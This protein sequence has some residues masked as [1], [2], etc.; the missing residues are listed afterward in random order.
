V[1]IAEVDLPL[2]SLMNGDFAPA[3]TNSLKILGMFGFRGDPLW[4]NN[5]AHLPVFDLLVALFFYIGLGIS[6]WRWRKERYL[7]IVLWLF[8]AAIPSIVTIDAPSSIRIINALPI[9]TIIPVIGLEVIQFFRPLST[10]LERLSPKTVEILALLL[11]IALLGVNIT[12]TASAI[13]YVWP[14][15]A[16]VQ[17][18]WQQAFTEIADYLDSS[19]GERAIALGGWT[20]ESMDP[21]TMDLLLR[22]EDLNLRYF[23]PTQSLLLPSPPSGEASTIFLP[24]VLPLEPILADRLAGWGA[25]QETLGTFRL[26]QIPD[27][28]AIQPQFQNETLFGNE[29]T[30]L[31]YDLGG[32]TEKLILE[33]DGGRI[34]LLTYW[35]VVAPGSGPRR[36]FLHAVTA[37]GQIVAQ[38]DRNGAPAAYWQM[39]DILLQRHTLQVPPN[40]NSLIYALGLYDPETGQRLSTSNGADHLQL[41]I[42]GLGK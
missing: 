35:R 38:D 6:L 14:S 7:F 28:P 22:R 34:D 12:R 42:D 40:E 1:R 15:N 26:W 31:G 21:P 10:V 39:G 18:V 16:E 3:V 24:A 13:F 23:E 8:T 25:S 11:L 27:S 32:S 4:R 30:F 2:R 33:D 9:L 41:E 37:D 5:V 36:F 20:P 19:E 17:F 29:I